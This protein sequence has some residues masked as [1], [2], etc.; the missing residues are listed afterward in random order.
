MVWSGLIKRVNPDTS[1]FSWKSIVVLN[2]DF[3]KLRRVIETV[4]RISCLFNKSVRNN[5]WNLNTLQW[6]V[7]IYFPSVNWI[8]RMKLN[9]IKWIVSGF[10]STNNFLILTGLWFSYNV[11]K[12]FQSPILIISFAS[13]RPLVIKMDQSWLFLKFLN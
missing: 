3:F 12:V 6:F 2:I 1:E 13:D 10:P 8:L 4:F 9:S 11:P 5:L 7:W